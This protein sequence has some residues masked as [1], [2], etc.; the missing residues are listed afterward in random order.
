MTKHLLNYLF[1]AV[2]LVTL[3]GCS[4]DDDKDTAPT[5]AALLT[6]QT[7]HGA[8]LYIN[9]T[10]ATDN[11]QIKDILFDIKTVA[12]TFKDDREYTAT[13]SQIHEGGVVEDFRDEGTWDLIENNTKIRFNF[14]PS[15][16]EIKKL[17]ADELHIS[18][19]LENPDGDI[20]FELRFVK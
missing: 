20:T 8:K 15:D 7:W 5:P 13:Y 9:G 11:A 10:A 14:L 3:F 16:S 4:K 1:A 19:V 18:S 17:T 6:A 2:L 12:L